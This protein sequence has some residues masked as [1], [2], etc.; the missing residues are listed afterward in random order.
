MTKS[1]KDKEEGDHY[2]N[3]EKE[4]DTPASG[5]EEHWIDIAERLQLEYAQ[6][7]QLMSDFAELQLRGDT[8]GDTD[9]ESSTLSEG[10]VEL[11]RE[12]CL[13]EAPLTDIC[14]ILEVEP[15]E[16]KKMH[17]IAVIMMSH[18]A[19]TQGEFLL[20]LPQAKAGV[21]K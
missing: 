8:S 1:D 16:K 14:K 10:Q 2:A 18:P 15:H 3:S 11:V 6:T 4:E 12:M 7:R 19:D 17:E 20:V 9:E 13:Q 5:E 21:E